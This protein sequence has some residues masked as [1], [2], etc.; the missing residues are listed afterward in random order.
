MALNMCVYTNYI[1]KI[2]GQHFL[3]TKSTININKNTKNK[4][5]GIAF[6]P[7]LGPH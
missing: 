2:E 3:K 7:F 1:F 5:D 6:H 4:M